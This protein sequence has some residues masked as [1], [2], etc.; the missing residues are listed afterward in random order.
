MAR[1]MNILDSRAISQTVPNNDG[2]YKAI[3]PSSMIHFIFTKSALMQVLLPEALPLL[4]RVYPP[5]VGPSGA[6]PHMN[7]SNS[8]DIGISSFILTN[9]QRPRFFPQQVNGQH[10]PY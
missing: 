1:L 8:P 5:D 2:T 3:L 10:L 9:S 6:P 4:Q 7:R